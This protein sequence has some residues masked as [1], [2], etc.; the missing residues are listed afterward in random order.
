MK[1]CEE[2]NKFY[3]PNI[4][5][6]Q[7]ASFAANV[8]WGFCPSCKAIH[9]VADQAAKS[10]QMSPEWRNFFSLLAVGTI[11]VTGAIILDRLTDA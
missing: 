5:Q 2:C 3:V 1:I 9:E 10:P 6:N 7:L 4:V 8:F 11:F